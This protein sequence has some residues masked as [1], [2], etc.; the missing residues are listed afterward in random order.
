MNKEQL[1]LIMAQRT[2]KTKREAEHWLNH[3][4][5]IVKEVLARR[6]QLRILTFGTFT[7]ARRKT[8]HVIHPQ[9]RQRIKIPGG[10]VPV[11]RPAKF[12]RKLV[13]GKVVI[14]RKRG[15]PRKGSIA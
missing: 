6:G 13:S 8:R 9:T 10:H 15:R 1:V 11:F 3:F 14:K 2:S 7:T 12:L 5:G 4:T